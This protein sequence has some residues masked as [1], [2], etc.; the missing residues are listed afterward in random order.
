MGSRL[1]ILAA[2]M[3]FQLL[4]G[5]LQDNL[6]NGNIIFFKKFSTLR[7]TLGVRRMT[8]SKF[9]TEDLQICAIGLNSVATATW[10]PGFVHPWVKITNFFQVRREVE[11][12]FATDYCWWASCRL[13]IARMC[14]CSRTVLVPA[15]LVVGPPHSG[16][17]FGVGLTFSRHKFEIISKPLARKWAQTP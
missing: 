13:T 17:G 4:F 16:Q 10:C 8:W 14:M 12:V 7:K 15:K 3:R 5:Q 1:R 9:H 2:L 11:E 6:N